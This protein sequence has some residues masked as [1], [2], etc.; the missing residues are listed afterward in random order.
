MNHLVH[1]LHTFHASFTA[2][3]KTNFQNSRLF[4]VI[5]ISGIANFLN[6]FVFSSTNSLVKLPCKFI[7]KWFLLK[8]REVAQG[9]SYSD[10]SAREDACCTGAAKCSDQVYF[11]PSY[12]TN[13]RVGF[14]HTHGPQLLHVEIWSHSCRRLVP[15]AY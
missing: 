8:A 4:A 3:N 14:D 9:R 15:Y 10:R 13:H 7:M 11:L 6:D 1:A 5:E 2:M 12:W